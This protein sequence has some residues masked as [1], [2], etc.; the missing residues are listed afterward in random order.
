MSVSYD[1]APTH[2]V[3][4]ALTPEF[5]MVAFTSALEPLRLANRVSGQELYAWR[6]YSANGEPVQA[7]NGVALS[8]D[9]TF[10]DIGPMAEFY[11][12][13]GIDVQAGGHEKLIPKL[14]KL[15][16]YGGAIGALCTGTY[17]LA[18]AGLL[19]GMR[20]SIHWENFES[21]R[22]QFPDIDVTQDLYVIDANRYT[23]AGGTAAIDMMLALIARRHRSEIANLVVDELIYHRIR[24]AHEHQRMGLRARL[25]ISHPKLIAVI[26]EMEKQLEEPLSCVEL[27]RH[28]GLSARQLERLFQKYIGERPTRYYLQLRLTRARYLL[29]QTSMPIL[30]IGLACGFVSASHFSKCYSEYFGRTPSDERKTMRRSIDAQ[31]GRSVRPPAGS[32]LAHPSGV[33]GKKAKV[34]A[35]PSK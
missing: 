34:P 26:S 5:S 35:S 25:G 17:V 28:A 13:T 20:C 23:C 24:D 22:E 6:L 10:A 9:G 21:F 18:K 8:V 7:S 2:V 1:N 14:R 4:F 3:G 16:L 11:V 15:T 29:L 33:D 27:A 31:T 30:S 19:D 12:C 32:A